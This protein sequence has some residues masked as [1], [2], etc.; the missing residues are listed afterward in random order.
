MKYLKVLPE[1]RDA[2]NR[3]R[4]FALEE[5]LHIVLRKRAIFL[6]QAIVENRAPK[7][8]P[9]ASQLGALERRGFIRLSGKKWVHTELGLL[10]LAFAVAGGVISQPGDATIT[11]MTTKKKVA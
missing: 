5:N 8:P 6:L 7:D 11:K 9:N 4:A 1:D 3:F 2:I 10:A